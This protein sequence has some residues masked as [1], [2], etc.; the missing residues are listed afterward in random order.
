MA[1]IDFLPKEFGYVVLCI[2]Y[3]IIM[4]I[5]LTLQVGNA[6][7]KYKVLYP[8]MYSKD[9]NLFNCIQR[10][11]QNTLEQLPLIYV[12]LTIV[13]L[14]CPKYAAVCGAIY[15]TSRF[16]YAWGYYTGDPKKRMNGSYGY[17][18]QLGL[19]LGM[20]YVGFKQ[21]GCCDAYLPF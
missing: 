5:Y 17:I 12:A 15:I 16:S 2:V 6:R 19:F 11:H 1:P 3:S 13:G 20:L 18:G 7:K 4:N 8:A 14:A 10:A 21:L 9:S